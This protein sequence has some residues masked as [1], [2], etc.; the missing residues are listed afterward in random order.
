MLVFS[1][2][3]IRKGLRPAAL[4]EGVGEGTAKSGETGKQWRKESSL[5]LVTE[6]HLKG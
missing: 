2:I 3:E 1:E 5:A 4:R 6:I